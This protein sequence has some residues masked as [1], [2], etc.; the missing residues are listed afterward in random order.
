MKNK[1]TNKEQGD[2]F[3]CPEKD[4]TN[5]LFLTSKAVCSILPISMRTLQSYR[6]KRI[7]PFYQ[8]G[9]KVFYNPF[10]LNEFLEKHHVKPSKRRR[11]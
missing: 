1:S 4:S 8:V 9:N 6:K 10:Q 11:V 3:N 2:K 7:I 5:R